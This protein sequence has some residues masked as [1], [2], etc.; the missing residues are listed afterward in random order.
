MNNLALDLATKTGWALKTCHLESGV[1]VFDLKRGESRGM[2]FLRFR[3]WLKEMIEQH[4]PDVLVFEQAH[5]RGGAATE[6]AVGLATRV[7]EMACEYGIEYQSVHTGM[8]KKFATG[9]GN[10][11]KDV[12]LAAA[13]DR[14]P[15]QEI[16]DDNQ[17]D[18]LWLLAWGMNELGVK[19]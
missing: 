3:A 4:R 9:K 13:R 2:R 15:D 18:A 6:V 16:E 12:M 5:H 1:Q 14:W 11:G 17:A 10:A 7:M 8:L 19:E